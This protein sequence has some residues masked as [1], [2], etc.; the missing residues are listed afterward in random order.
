MLRIV[1]PSPF[2]FETA[3]TALPFC[4]GDKGTL[5]YF[6]EETPCSVNQFTPTIP[7]FFCLSAKASTFVKYPRQP[8]YQDWGC[9]CIR[10][11]AI[12][13]PVLFGGNRNYLC[14]QWVLHLE[15]VV[16]SFST[17]SSCELLSTTI[18][19]PSICSKTHLKH[20]VLR[21]ADVIVEMI[22]DSCKVCFFFFL[23]RWFVFYFCSAERQ[24]LVNTNI[25]N[26]SRPV[27]QKLL[28]PKN[29]VYRRRTR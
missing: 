5:F 19:S 11:C 8:W 7:V 22:T 3:C 18:I 23:W 25:R 21:I 13:T 16:S 28:A 12:A 4:K 29:I 14:F 6:Q 20:I 1:F 27:F 17:L 10:P 26:I 24:L 15:N 9:K 2:T